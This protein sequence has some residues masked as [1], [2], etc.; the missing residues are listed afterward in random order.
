MDGR[1]SGMAHEVEALRKRTSFEGGPG[2]DSI[3][4]FAGTQRFEIERVLGAGGMGV[5]YQARDRER[6]AR[7][8]LKTLRVADGV[9]VDRFKKEFRALANITHP[10]L[11]ELGELYHD[12]GQWFFTMEL[13][14]GQSFVEH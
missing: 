14:D 4:H 7:V 3:P 11:V 1:G 13:L 9:G 6:D 2:P 12:A 10:N 5:V 8:A